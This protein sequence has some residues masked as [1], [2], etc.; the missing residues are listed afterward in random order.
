MGTQ[1][2]LLGLI[3]LS[4]RE[5]A[6]GGTS[7]AVAVVTVILSEILTARRYRK[8]KRT[9]L[10]QQRRAALDKIDKE[11]SHT[12]DDSFTGGPTLRTRVSDSSMLRRVAA[13]LPGYSRLPA[14]CPLPLP[15]EELDDLFYTEKASFARPTFAKD[16]SDRRYFHDPAE[17]SRGLVY[18]SEM[19][20]PVPVIWLPNDRAGVATS[21]AADLESYHGLMAIVDPEEPDKE[22]K[23]VR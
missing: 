14:D 21:E 8:P 5:W 15:T 18:P 19:L 13:L 12:D 16:H 2:A 3:L 6:L 10:S 11:I 22:K 23:N 7:I 1:P 9:R 20:A 17:S 4:R